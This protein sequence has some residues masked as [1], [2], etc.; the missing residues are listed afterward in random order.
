M[1]AWLGPIYLRTGCFPVAAVELE[2]AE[3][4]VLRDAT[5]RLASMEL[6]ADRE[7][8]LDA[9]EQYGLALKFASGELKADLDIVLTAVT[10]CGMAYRNS[11]SDRLQQRP[12]HLVV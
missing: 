1:L 9:V 12:A 11:T 3:A 2:A 10:Q 4:V 6:K 5:T 8:V 7:V